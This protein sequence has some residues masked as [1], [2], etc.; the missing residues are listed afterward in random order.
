VAGLLR[1][2][3]APDRAAV[4][5]ALG[6]LL[7]PTVSARVA[8]HIVLADGGYGQRLELTV[9]PAITLDA[10]LL[11]PDG[12]DEVP[13]VLVTID[14]GGKAVALA[15]P[16]AA[17]ARARGWAVL[18][19]DLR[20]TGESA[21]SE[22]EVATAAWLLDRDL[23]ADRVRDLRACV[24]ML[25]ERY[26]TGQQIDKRRIAVHGDGPFALVALLAAAL[27]DDIAGAV[28][29]GFVAGL[30]E[31]LVESPQITPMVFGF[32]A[33]EAYDV[34]DL[35]RLGRLSMSGDDAGEMVARLLAGLGS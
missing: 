12:W 4:A 25:S 32:R 9:A 14:E 29:T 27:D 34:P 28:G 26:S 21:A 35:V 11:L 16:A 10:V 1:A 7:D 20:G 17:T 31:L 8:N 19:P 23:L 2:G 18:A 24:R 5:T 3:R 22:F 30:E 13:G 33:L 6:G 15:G